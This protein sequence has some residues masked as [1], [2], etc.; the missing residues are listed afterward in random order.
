MIKSMTGYGKAEALLEGKKYTVE[1]RSLNHRYLEISLRL[2]GSLSVLET[3][4]KRRIA[5]RFSRGRIEATVRID[6]NGSMEEGSLDL[7]LPLLKNYFILLQRLKSEF[8]LKGDVTLENLTGFKDV[9]VPREEG[10]NV[11]LLA[12]HIA[13]V[14][15]EAIVLLTEMRVK[16]GEMLLIDLEERVIKV[17]E[18]LGRIS[19]RAPR[20][21]QEY[22]RRL[23][24]RIRELTSGVDVDA[25]RLSQEVAI[26]ADKSDVTEEIVRLSSH[27]S[28]FHEMLRTGDAVGRKIDFLIQEMNREINTIGS[29]TGD[30]EISRHVIEIKSELGKLREQVQNI[31]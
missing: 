6:A 25:A 12:G 21:V 24:E 11:E 16:E 31:E 14:L 20:C 18:W 26:M 2:P 28:Q 7:N 5:E 22:Q 4:I 23:I 13:T 9:F 29:K 17:E 8:Q 30:L 1:I 15:D 10:V 27:I 3:E 19:D